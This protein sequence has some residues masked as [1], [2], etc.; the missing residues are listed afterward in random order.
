VNCLEARAEF[1]SLVDGKIGLSEWVPLEAHLAKCADCRKS[2]DRLYSMKPRNKPQWAR[3]STGP[4][5][6]PDEST[7][8]IEVVT[9]TH[10]SSH[11]AVWVS[12]AA[13]ALMLGAVGG[14]VAYGSHLNLGSSLVALLYKVR[15]EGRHPEVAPAPSLSAPPQNL[16]PEGRQ[17]EV[18]AAPPPS[19]PP[20]EPVPPKS[21]PPVELAPP[22]PAPPVSAPE[23]KISGKAKESSARPPASLSPAPSLPSRVAKP[24][25]PA[26][27]SEVTAAKSDPEPAAIDPSALVEAGK[28]DV[29]VQLSVR[30]RKD[31]ERDLTMLLTRVGGTKFGHGQSTTLMASVPRSSYSEFTRGLTQIGSWQLEAGRS[32]LPDPVHV[33]VKL[34]R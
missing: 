4:I 28:I 8:I 11:R 27:S 14:L 21:T 13:V 9:P 19:A 2:L 25:R 22:K 17:T 7:D 29:A 6:L 33:A 12:V 1:T 10:R 18:A 31:A 34:A 24:P 3:A 32:S 16:R 23:P 26:T 30:N 5:D 20:P 15:P